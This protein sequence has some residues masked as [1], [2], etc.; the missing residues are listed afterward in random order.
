MTTKTSNSPKLLFPPLLC[1]DEKV[2]ITHSGSAV[3]V[4]ANGSGK[5][6]LGKWIEL[7]SDPQILV[8][9]IS[10]QRVLNLPDHVEV[11]SLEQSY[12]ALLYGHEEPQYANKKHKIAHRNENCRQN[13]FGKVLSTL[14]AR[15]TDRNEQY[16][17]QAKKIKNYTEVSDSPSDILVKLWNEILPHRKISLNGGKVR[18]TNALQEYHGKE[19]SDGERVALYLMGQCLCAPS[20]S[21]FIIDEPELHLHSSIMKAM[22]DRLEAVKQ[23]CLF[24]YITHD[25]NFASSRINATKIWIKEFDGKDKWVWELIP[26]NDDIPEELLLEL[27]GNR[28]SVIFCEGKKSGRDHNLYQSVYTDFHVVPVGGCEEVIKSVRS[29]NNNSSFSHIKAFGLIDR[30]YRTEEEIQGL[31]KSDIHCI[32]AATIENIFINEATL[33]AVATELELNPDDI[34]ER[35]LSKIKDSLKLEVEYQASIRTCRKIESRLH[36]LEKAVGLEKIKESII[37]AVAAINVESIF[38]ENFKLYTDLLEDNSLNEI[39]K[40]YKNKGLVKIV[41]KD[42]LNLEDYNK[43]IF[44]MLN[45]DNRNSILEAIKTHL[46]RI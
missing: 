44:R 16:T 28:R 4:G 34:I 7:N 2:E 14:V 5:S 29:L 35:A 24:V 25:L 11:K 31:V 8:H 9:C 21:I 13:D 17:N 41:G 45:S 19:M 32:A 6:R 38:D 20:G 18:V 37:N 10:A 15:D 40:Y 39:L 42:I 33:R 27:L 1:N 23:D 36:Q 46:P 43:F 30:D 12:H 3:I 22:W 26:K